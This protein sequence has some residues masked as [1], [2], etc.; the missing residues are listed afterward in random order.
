M[1]GSGAGRWFE[2][3]E[4]MYTVIYIAIE[5]EYTVYVISRIPFSSRLNIFL[6]HHNVR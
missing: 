3:N 4:Q 1:G 5:K 6:S 2:L